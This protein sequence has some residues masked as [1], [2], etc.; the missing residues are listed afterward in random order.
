[1]V[2]REYSTGKNRAHLNEFWC[3][4]RAYKVNILYK[5]VNSK[6]LRIWILQ[7]L[8]SFS[9]SCLESVSIRE[10][11]I[12]TS[13]IC[14]KNELEWFACC[15]GSYWSSKY[16][17]EL[18]RLGCV[19]GLGARRR[20]RLLVAK[21]HPVLHLHAGT[22][23]EGMQRSQVEQFFCSI[24]CGFEP[25]PAWLCRT[26]DFIPDRRSC[27]PSA[28]LMIFAQV[29]SIFTDFWPSSAIYIGSASSLATK[30]T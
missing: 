23:T 30:P 18:A 13:I 9:L 20:R 7:I 12:Y 6:I 8:R 24:K 16:G 25:A 19:K 21:P 28:L 29:L 22:S 11:Y 4:Q 10:W 5:T 1:M 17:I 27:F 14:K 3:L 26:V 2:C 15:W